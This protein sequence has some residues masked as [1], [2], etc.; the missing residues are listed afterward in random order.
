ME[1]RNMNTSVGAW[2]NNRR[3][4]SKSGKG[5]LDAV[6]AV[7]VERKWVTLNG[8][9]RE[10]G[11]SRPFSVT[12]VGL[13]WDGIDTKNIDAGDGSTHTLSLSLTHLLS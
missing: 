4:T 3:D 13:V 8:V 2:V 11:E 10:E 1:A 6:T 7:K 12:R 5:D 9:K